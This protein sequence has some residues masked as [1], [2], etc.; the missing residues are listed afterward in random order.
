MCRDSIRLS[1]FWK[2]ELTCKESNSTHQSPIVAELIKLLGSFLQLKNYAH[3]KMSGQ[4]LL[5]LDMSRQL[6][7]VVYI[8][9]HMLCSCNIPLVIGRNRKP[10][11]LVD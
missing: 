8:V 4:K 11:S 7:L 2:T 9:Y 1:Y 6:T 3:Y 10:Q 5:C